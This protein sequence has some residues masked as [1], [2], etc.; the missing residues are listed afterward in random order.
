[1]REA[2]RLDDHATGGIASNPI[3]A[4]HLAAEYVVAVYE[5]TIVVFKTSGE[6]L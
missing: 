6:L 1:M 2:F 5:T 4:V 3:V